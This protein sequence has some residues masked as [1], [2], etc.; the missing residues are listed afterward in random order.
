VVDHDIDGVS[1]LHCNFTAGA[2][3]LLNRN[4]ALGLVPE[5]DNDVF[6][7]NADNPSLKNL[8]RGRRREMAVVVEKVFVAWNFLVGWFVV[9]VYG[10]YASASH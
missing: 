8:I 7:G 3:K 1:G 9:R 2:L 6:G 5:I 10:H 4:Q